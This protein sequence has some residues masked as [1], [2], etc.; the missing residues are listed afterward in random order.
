MNKY[1]DIL[2]L[3]SL[4]KIASGQSLSPSYNEIQTSLPYLLNRLSTVCNERI[5]NHLPISQYERFID[6]SDQFL[7]SAF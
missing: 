4:I 3:I 7:S 2:E 6:L 1:S 5:Q